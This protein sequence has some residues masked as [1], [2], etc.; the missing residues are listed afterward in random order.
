MLYCELEMDIQIGSGAIMTMNCAHNVKNLVAAMIICAGV[1]AFGQARPTITLTAPSA[2]VAVADGN[3]FATTVV[4]NQW[5]MDRLRDIALDTGYN[6]PS[7]AGGIWTGVSSAQYAYFFPLSPGFIDVTYSNYYSRYDKGTP[8]GPLNPIDASIY[9]HIS[10]RMSMKASSRGDTTFMWTKHWQTWP[11]S[12]NPAVAGRLW[13]A[14]KE[15][16]YD[17]SGYVVVDNP[18]GYRIYDVGLAGTDWLDQRDSLLVL[19]NYKSYASWSG[20]IYGFEFWPSSSFPIGETVN[21]DWIRLYD[22]AHSPTVTV[23]WTTTDMPDARYA[24]WLY[25]DNDNNGYNGDLFMTGI[26]D[27]GTYALRTAAL[28]PGDYYIYLKAISYENSGFTTLDTSAYSEKI[29]IDSPPIVKITAP[30]YTSGDDY[31]TK[32]LSNAWDFASSTDVSSSTT[33][34]P[35]FYAS[36]IMAGVASGDAQIVLNQKRNGTTIPI[37]TQRYRYLTFTL[38]ADFSAMPDLFESVRS[39]LVTKLTWWNQAFM[40]DGTYSQDL[41]LLEDQHAYTIDLWDNS[42]INPRYTQNY[43]QRGWKALPQ[44]TTLR[45]DPIQTGVPIWFWLD[46]IKICADNAPSNNIYQLVWNIVDPDSTSI[47]VKVYYRY[48]LNGQLYEYPRPLTTIT[49]RPGIRRYKW[50]MGNLPIGDYFVRIEANDG[51]NTYSVTSPLPIKVQSTY[52]RMNV[53]VTDP[54]VFNEASGKWWI[55]LTDTNG[56]TGM[57]VQSW[58]FPGSVPVRG[59]YNGDGKDDLAV[60]YSVTGRWYIR[61]IYNNILVWNFPWGWPG[62]TPVPGDYDGDGKDDLAVL[63]ENSG[64]WYVWSLAKNTAIVWNLAWGWPGA[65]PVSG[66]YDNDGVSDLAVLDIN[67]GKW[68]IYS[69][70]KNTAL[71]WNLAWGWPG[72]AYVPGDYDGDGTSDLAVYDQTA[73]KWY[74]YSL[75]TKNA[76]YWATAWGFAGGIPV[77][78]DF[79]LDAKADLIVYSPANGYWCIRYSSGGSEIAGP[80]GGTGYIPVPANYDGK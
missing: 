23:T 9:T 37:N 16:S 51:I 31:A 8:Y 70:P 65:K 4:G 67:I 12:T 27:D 35:I 79:N 58:G 56:P 22:Y 33:I 63:D 66:D 25:V 5:N 47:V 68:F 75:V 54:A 3:D 15:P 60:F 30:S 43:P 17:N 52:P 24:I 26:T 7:V 41:F 42:I 49:Q 6:H 77:S 13:I 39:G 48:N 11:A 76:I 1:Q 38:Q 74:V 55:V 78:A 20:T 45:F 46:D 18:T 80:W 28:P 10:Y 19:P 53:K 61:D 2:P 32:E 34:A 64:K 36:G 57:S 29:H 62:A 73:G 14:D 50:Q 21:F 59:D 69:I 40:T 44:V 72:C 71:A